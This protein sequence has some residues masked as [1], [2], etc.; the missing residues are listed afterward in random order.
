MNDEPRKV[1]I[2]MFPAGSEIVAFTDVEGELVREAA[3]KLDAERLLDEERA[4]QARE[5][6]TVDRAWLL[7]VLRDLIA[8]IEHDH[9]LAVR[10][11]DYD[12]RCNAARKARRL[13]QDFA[14][15]NAKKEPQS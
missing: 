15:C 4:R 10:A 5:R 14:F 3:R 12:R 11:G 1:I 2:G 6:V 8:R 9:A 7:S 13:R